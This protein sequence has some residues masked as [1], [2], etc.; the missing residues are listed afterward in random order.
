M[1][2]TSDE[3]CGVQIFM[4]IMTKT[5]AP[6]R[7]ATRPSNLALAQARMVAEHIAGRENRRIKLVQVTTEGDA[8]AH[9]PLR[10]IGGKGVFV[11]ALEEALLSGRA[12]FAVHSLKDVPSRLAPEFTLAA[13]G[14]REDARDALISC[15]R[16]SLADLPPAARIG[17]S[18]LRRALLLQKLLRKLRADVSIHPVR[19]NVDTRIAKL[20][21]GQFHA[22]VL[23]AAG[24]HRVG[25]ADHIVEYFPVRRLLP[26]PGQGLL[27]IEVLAE[28]RDLVEM[29]G[30][31]V[32]PQASLAGRIERR[33]SELLEGDCTLPIA[34]HAEVRDGNGQ[35][36]VWIASTCGRLQ[37]SAEVQGE[38]APALAELAVER[39]L[40]SGGQEVMATFRASS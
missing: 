17:T 36:A 38:A 9:R 39:L 24:L 40:A 37:A 16:V 10:E 34:A 27:A 35:L 2:T 29:L 21:A 18:S 20:H 31:L 33:V 19:G 32:P 6:L 28:R 26:A 1:P 15:P 3:S 14:W 22:L 4:S 7:L 11:K 8:E 30:T 23:A 25:L 5:D 13:V 12:D